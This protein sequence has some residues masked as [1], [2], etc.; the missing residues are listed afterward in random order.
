MKGED[1]RDP[2][3]KRF[4]VVR[5]PD[6]LIFQIQRFTKNNFFV[7]KN[8]TIVQYPVS[9]LDMGP[10]CLGEYNYRWIEHAHGLKLIFTLLLE[11]DGQEIYDLV[12]NIVHDGE[13]KD[14]SY[15]IHVNH[16][17]TNMWKEIQVF[18]ELVSNIF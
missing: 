11:D 8:P 7:E 10:Y 2:L 9:S 13:P 3:L 6:V 1:R 4:R 12:A 15:R 14:G 5:L 18:F 16:K 17:L